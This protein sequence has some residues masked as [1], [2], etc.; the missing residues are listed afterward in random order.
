MPA[1]EPDQDVL[2]EEIVKAADL[3]GL[4]FAEEAEEKEEEAE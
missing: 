4:L 2:G 1:V 3:E